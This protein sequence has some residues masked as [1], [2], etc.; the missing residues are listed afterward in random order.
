MC[1]RHFCVVFLVV[2]PLLALV[3]CAPKETEAN[4][5][6]SV[7]NAPDITPVIGALTKGTRPIGVTKVFKPQHIGRRCVIVARTPERRDP[8]PPPMG[9]VR[10]MGPTIIYT[11]EIHDVSADTLDIKADYPSSGNAKIITVPKAD[12]Q[13]LY[14]G[15]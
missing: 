11:A 9:M 10:L 4:S 15:S 13:S 7:S 8:P 6:S 1:V 14:L 12:I 2:A 3:G 5:Y